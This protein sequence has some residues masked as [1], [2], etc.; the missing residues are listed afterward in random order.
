M[1]GRKRRERKESKMDGVYM[2]GWH[3]ARVGC[4]CVFRCVSWLSIFCF[5]G[6][7]VL[8]MVCVSLTILR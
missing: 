4:V 7:G 1:T 8:E 5:F 6:R 3:G 2:A